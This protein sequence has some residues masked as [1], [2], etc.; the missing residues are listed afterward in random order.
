MHA[1]NLSTEYKAGTKYKFKVSLCCLGS[2]YVNTHNH[3]NTHTNIHTQSYNHTHT[4][5]KLG[6]EIEWLPHRDRGEPNL[7]KQHRT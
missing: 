1:C 3:T 6:P 5:T 7:E 4:H 2:F